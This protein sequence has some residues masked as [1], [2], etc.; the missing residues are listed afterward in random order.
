MTVIHLSARHLLAPAARE[1]SRW[2]EFAACARVDPELFHPTGRDTLMLAAAKLV[3]SDCPV[4]RECLQDALDRG[5]DQ[6][7]RGGLSEQ[8]RRA[9]HRRPDPRPH[10]FGMAGTA[11]MIAEEPREYLALVAEGRSAYEI[12]KALRTNVQT[13]NNVARLLA[14]AADTPADGEAAAEQE[15]R[16][17]EDV[18]C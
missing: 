16:E 17:Q 9:I 5:E 13:V 18:A 2:E 7:V 10:Q 12:A 4:A 15:P 11:E 8:E 14:E 3:C 1:D 6:G